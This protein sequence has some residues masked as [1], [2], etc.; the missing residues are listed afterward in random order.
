M[1]KIYI[2]SIL[3]SAF[4]LGSCEDDFLERAPMDK[5][6]DENF[7]QTEEQL[8]L[9]VDAMYGYLKAKNTVD[10]E[11]MGDNTFWPSNNNFKLIGSGNFSYDLSTINNEWR[12]LYEGIRQ[13]NTFLANY[14]K[15]DVQ[16]PEHAEALAAQ[17]R[18]IRA[19][20]YSYLTAF[21]GDVPLVTTPLNIDELYGP[22]DPR[23]EVVDFI[24]ADLDTAAQHLPAEIPSGDDAGRLAKGAAL[25]LKARVALYNERWEVAEEAAKAVMDMGVYELFNVGDPSSNYRRLFTYEGKLSGGRNQE[26]IISRLHLEGVTDHNLSRE[27]QVPDQG[28]RWNPTKSLV[29]DYLMIDGLPI[30]KSP[31]YSVA[32]YNEV[33]EDRDPRM[34]QTI[35]EP[36]SPWGG[37]Y[38]SS[39]EHKDADP[40]NDHPDIFV[41]PKFS[42][43]KRGAATYTGY[44][45]TKYVELSTVGQVSRDVNDIHLLRYA[46]VLLTYAEA[47]L[48]QGELTQEVVDM[49]INLLRERVGM[50][51]M[52]LAELTANG[53]DIREEIHRERR[54][55]LALEGQRY[56]DIIRWG[57]G[58]LLA[59]D[60]KGTN[61]NW[62]PNKEDAAGL[63][64]DDK[65]F[66]IVLDGNRFDDPR[67]YLW[68]VPLEQAQLNPELG[69]NP[70][71]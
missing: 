26:T 36:G 50:T 5:I 33:F 9:A 61:V 3:L 14:K 39:P 59:A 4:V 65:G 54:I 10:M 21:F 62:L 16:N 44:Y 20:L 25:A 41:V 42:S 27:I 28:V 40:G 55:E 64:T 56:F 8:E 17:V 43:D 51:P 57:K 32:T 53:L 68:P 13:A 35:L 37:R 11:I 19:Y 34:T 58:E 47:K 60:V 31:L 1:K 69:Q 7:W 18:I 30:G 52:V 6:T 12:G 24:L 22:R 63:R 67:N 2:I 48:E 45:F 38:D 29:D 71:W 70:G 66:I 15:A 49:T 46:E 23:A